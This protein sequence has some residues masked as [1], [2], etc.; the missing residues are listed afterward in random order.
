[1]MNSTAA[2]SLRPNGTLR[3]FPLRGAAIEGLSTTL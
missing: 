3:P 1:M 2:L